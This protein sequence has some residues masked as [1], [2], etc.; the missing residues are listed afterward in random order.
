M[1]EQT[2]RIGLIG[3]GGNTRAKHIPGLQ[4]IDDVYIFGVCNRTL[5][6]SRRA[7]QQ[8]GIPR[9]FE[10]WQELVHSSDVDA[11]VIGTWPY[12]HCPATLAALAADKHVLCEA[13]IAMNAREAHAMLD[14]SRARPHLVAQV[15]PAPHTLR[16]DPTIIHLIAEGYLGD[17]LAVE[18]RVGNAFVERDAPLHWRHDADLSGLNA[19]GLGIWY[20]AVM[21]WVGEAT[22]VTAMG[23]TFVPVRRDS[24]T[25]TKRAVRIPDHLDVIAHMAC[26][27]Q[28][29][30]RHS[31]IA[32]LSGRPEA[33]LFGSEGTLRLA[34]R[35]YG[36]RRGDEAL[37][38]IPIPPEEEGGWRVEQEFINAIRGLEPVTHT[39]FAVGV[40]YMEFT[41]A[42]ARSIA[43]GKAI[44]L[45]L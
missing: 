12:L 45:P 42:V 15:V 17:V 19:M 38:E 6:S 18:V 27:A 8:F 23:K 44:S 24:E 2:I 32:G 39:P 16:F 11:V 29:H 36:G 33:W 31:A 41:E 13:R 20:E 28:A 43:E 30:F 25:G 1:G 37:H 7:A 5:A 40:K 9:V 22:R 4:A 21:R 14:A 10:H 34:D 26:G 35:L 3:A